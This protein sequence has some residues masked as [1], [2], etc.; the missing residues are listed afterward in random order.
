MAETTRDPLITDDATDAAVHAW[1]AWSLAEY[2]AAPVDSD[3]RQMRAALEAVAPA[4][5]GRWVA[6]ALEAAAGEWGPGVLD[7]SGRSITAT[8]RELAAEHR[9]GVR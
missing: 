6:E 5:R 3:P 7:D 1:L 8:L 9:A 4:L 2:G